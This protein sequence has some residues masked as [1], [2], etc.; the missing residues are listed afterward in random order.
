VTRS[1]QD[2]VEATIRMDK[3]HALGSRVITVSTYFLLAFLP[4]IATINSQAFIITNSFVMLN[5]VYYWISTMTR[6]K[7]KM[8]G[9]LADSVI[10]SILFIMSMGLAG[11][12]VACTTD[13]DFLAKIAANSSFMI[14]CYLLIFSP[15]NMKKYEAKRKEILAKEEQKKKN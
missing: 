7:W 8:P 4:F 5:L 9:P 1:D 12:C 2:D 13:P 3:V 6:N 10:Y 15:G 11:F 14:Q